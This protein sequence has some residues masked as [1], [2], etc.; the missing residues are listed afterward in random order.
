VRVSLD[1][2]RE[3]LTDALKA[4]EGRILG[5]SRQTPDWSVLDPEGVRDLF[6]LPVD[7]NLEEARLGP[8]S[9]AVAAAQLESFIVEWLSD[10]PP[11]DSPDA[12]QLRAFSDDAH[13]FV[14]TL[15]V[16]ETTAR[17]RTERAHRRLDAW[18]DSSLAELNELRE[19]DIEAIQDLIDDGDLDSGHDARAERATIWEEQRERAAELTDFA[20]TLHDLLEEGRERT[21]VGI[22]QL[23][24]LFERA[25]EVLESRHPEL[26]DYRPIGQDTASEL[27]SSMGD[28]IVA[29]TDIL[30][31]AVDA[32]GQRSSDTPDE[33]IVSDAD[34]TIAED[35]APTRTDTPTDATRPGG[36]DDAGDSTDPPPTG[37]D[38]TDGPQP[39]DSA[40]LDNDAD[41][42]AH[43]V[44]SDASSTS[45]RPFLRTPP[46]ETERDGDAGTSNHDTGSETAEPDREQLPRRH[47]STFVDPAATDDDAD[48]GRG[49]GLENSSDVQGEAP[50]TDA[51]SADTSASLAVQ[52]D[53]AAADTNADDAGHTSDSNQFVRGQ[54]APALDA[55]ESPSSDNHIEPP[56]DTA[57]DSTGTE[58]G[59]PDV[60]E[61]SVATGHAPPVDS[62]VAGHCARFRSEWRPVPL[63]TIAAALA[64]PA[65]LVTSVLVAGLLYTFGFPTSNPLRAWPWLDSASVV[66]LLW[67]VAAPPLLGW[68]VQ[69][70]GWS[71]RLIRH[72]ELRQDGRLRLDSDGLMVHGLS[73]AWR[74]I[75]QAELC[76]FDAD[77]G[78]L[79]W[80]LEITPRHSPPLAIIAAVESPD[81]WHDSEAPHRSPPD[82]AWQTDP[83]TFHH[84]T[85]FLT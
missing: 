37:D 46:P 84:L 8:R 24:E 27:D 70:D 40:E 76:R 83:D 6:V 41:D 32:S 71:C 58:D 57:D 43:L 78:D 26:G 23:A 48:T 20:A 4:F 29:P 21:L 18:R 5:L 56:D 31:D 82:D 73:I 85:R 69:W 19:S 28:T 35:G 61:P 72:V 9:T 50:R 2:M 30:D 14:E 62:P 17:Q 1:K 49:L 39:S 36:T 45:S 25:C 13:A 79:G 10:D 67:L 60:P 68:R 34:D 22:Q 38:I 15:E 81:D 54:Q 16:I 42:T 52:L 64:M 12:Q 51:P 47:D 53:Q 63:S 55:D 44:R 74:H 77:D 11:D 65:L 66:A 59:T 7:G 3:E 80:L 33:A 75:E